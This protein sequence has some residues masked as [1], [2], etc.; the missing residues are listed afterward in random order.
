LYSTVVAFAINADTN[1]IYTTEQSGTLSVIDGNTNK[2]KNTLH[3]GKLPEDVTI[4]PVRDRIYVANPY[5][6]TIT[7]IDGKTVRADS[8][9]IET[10]GNNIPG[11]KVGR[12][13]L[14]V[15]VDP[16]N[17]KIYVVDGVSDSVSIIEGANDRVMGSL[18]VAGGSPESI[19]VNPGNNR[20]YVT[21]GS[22]ISI[23]DGNTNKVLPTKI[24]L[25]QSPSDMA[26]NPNNNTIYL[27]Y[28]DKVSVVDGQ[29][30][31]LAVGAIFY[32][33]PPDSGRITCN[34]KEIPPS[35]YIRVKSSSPCKVEPNNGF[36]FNSWTERLG[37]NSSRIITKAPDSGSLFSLSSSLSNNDYSTFAISSFGNFDAN[38]PSLSTAGSNNAFILLISLMAMSMLGPVTIHIWLF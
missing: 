12:N 20:I 32:L 18:K 22:T 34:G 27:A 14:K 5:L 3:V 13:P 9:N 19:A 30:N 38:L 31:D 23:I 26:V 35:I 7:V 11:I 33:N 36:M 1:T 37:P 29:T 28:D 8:Q 2:V 4:D 15:A 16:D 21:N 17:N 24:S 10:N 25:D 6:D